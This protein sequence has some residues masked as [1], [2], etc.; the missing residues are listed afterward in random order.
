MVYKCY[1]FI[2]M[3]KKIKF[4]IFC[5]TNGH[6]NFSYKGVDYLTNQKTCVQC[7]FYMKLKADLLYCDTLMQCFSMSAPGHT[8]VP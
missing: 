8:N 5:P 6:H 2:I 3:Q 7:Q 4:E 1:G